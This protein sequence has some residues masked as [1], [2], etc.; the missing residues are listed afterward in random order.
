MH[1]DFTSFVDWAI[2]GSVGGI[3]A[4]GVHLLSQ[5]K[6]SIDLLNDKMAKIIERTEWHTREIDKLEYRI[7]KLE[8]RK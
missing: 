1:I 5:M 4:Y 3:C 6:N 8:G 2:K 7:N